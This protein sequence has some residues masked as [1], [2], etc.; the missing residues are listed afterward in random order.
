MVIVILDIRMV[1]IDC[2]NTDDGRVLEANM[3]VI[4]EVIMGVM[5]WRWPLL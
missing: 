1:S 5:E 3:V 2:Y 4:L